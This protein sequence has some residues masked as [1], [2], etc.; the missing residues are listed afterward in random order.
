MVLGNERQLSF[1][2]HRRIQQQGQEVVIDDLAAEERRASINGKFH[3]RIHYA[4]INHDNRRQHFRN[5]Q[6]QKFV[7]THK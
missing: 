4:A 7:N 3:P 6:Q 2:H 5:M 1:V